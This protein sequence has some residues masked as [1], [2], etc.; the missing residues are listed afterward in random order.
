MPLEPDL[1]I[2]LSLG[3]ALLYTALNWMLAAK[4][5]WLAIDEEVVDYWL[6]GALAWTLVIVFVQPGLRIPHQ[7]M[8]PIFS[9]SSLYLKD[10]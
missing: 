1:V 5:G 7:T 3:L 8:I 2:L 6:Q 9:Y 10:L 4:S